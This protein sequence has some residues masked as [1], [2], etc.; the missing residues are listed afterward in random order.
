ML[1][2]F[3]RPP[4]WHAFHPIS[5]INDQLQVTTLLAEKRSHDALFLMQPIWCT[6]L[7]SMLCQLPPCT[8]AL[9]MIGFQRRPLLT[10][11]VVVVSAGVGTT[12]SLATSFVSP[13]PSRF[14]K[15]PHPHLRRSARVGVEH[16]NPYTF[17]ISFPSK[18]LM[19]SPLRRTSKRLKEA[20]NPLRTITTEP[21]PG[22]NRTS[23]SSYH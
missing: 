2:A 9:F 17:R 4:I 12:G 20:N 3:S 6:T 8:I 14:L 15:A 11:Y 19:A 1:P 18:T 10:Y 16:F 22:Q 23:S 7:P 5:I 21:N 13:L